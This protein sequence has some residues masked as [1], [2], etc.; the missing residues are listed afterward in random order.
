MTAMPGFDYPTRYLAEPTHAA[1]RLTAQ[2]VQIRIVEDVS[3]GST[4]SNQA[5][6]A[7]G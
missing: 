6:L 4:A 5:D 2:I 7:E 1:L 3:V